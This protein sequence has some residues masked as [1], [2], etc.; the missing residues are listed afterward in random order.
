MVS[1]TP[2]PSGVVPLYGGN[3]GFLH[4]SRI[5]RPGHVSEA[6]I[7]E[8][9]GVPDLLREGRVLEGGIQ[10]NE[11]ALADRGLEGTFAFRR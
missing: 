8:E 4:F 3:I 9:S 5:G 6:Q 11:Y 2:L 7:W 1:L 10:V